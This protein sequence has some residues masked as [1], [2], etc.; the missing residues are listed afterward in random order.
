MKAKT[1]EAVRIVDALQPLAVAVDSLQFDPANARKHSPR[2][3]EAIKTSLRRFGQRLPIV[4]QREGMIV[5]AGNARLEAVRQLGW[6]EIAAVVVDEGDVD[7]VSFAIA[8]NRTAELSEWDVEV[9]TSLL[10]LP[11]INIE[12]VGFSSD[13]LTAML[14]ES[15]KKVPDFASDSPGGQLD[16]FN[17]EVCET[18]G[19]RI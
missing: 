5:R 8:D 1:K 2:N 14:E 16:E 19:R 17:G 18:C 13:E 6:K 12:D 7:A 4:V 3:M 11:D 15:G 9:L 10:Q